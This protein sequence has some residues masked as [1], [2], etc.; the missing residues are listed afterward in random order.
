MKIRDGRATL[1]GDN[2]VTEIASDEIEIVADDGRTLF[3]VRM[4]PDGSILLHAGH[5]CKH[6][7]VILDDRMSIAPRDCRSITVSRIPYTPEP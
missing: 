6:L 7:D 1:N 4:R 3:G 5:V 2:T